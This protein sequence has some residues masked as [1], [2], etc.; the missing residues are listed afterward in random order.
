MAQFGAETAFNR[1]VPFVELDVLNESTSYLKRTLGLHDVEVL[2]VDDAKAKGYS[3][4]MMEGAEP[5]SPAFEYYN[6]QS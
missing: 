3:P 5:G 2:L 1:T 4:V 6:V